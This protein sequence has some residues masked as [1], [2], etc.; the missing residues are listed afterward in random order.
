[1][2]REHDVIHHSI[3]VISLSCDIGCLSKLPARV[4]EVESV[5]E[6]QDSAE[7]PTSPLKHH[8]AITIPQAVTGRERLQAGYER[9]RA[10][11]MSECSHHEPSAP[12]IPPTR[13]QSVSRPRRDRA[14]P[15][16]SPAILW[17]MPNL[18]EIA[19]SSSQAW[20]TCRASF[21]S[22]EPTD[23]NAQPRPGARD[24]AA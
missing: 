4:D 5:V 18:I 24:L 17:A 10:G 3:L 8:V 11:R 6:R 23:P 16:A 19:I 2:S 14:P 20:R 1:M 21:L 7:W 13:V 9:S 15:S 22:A 12:S